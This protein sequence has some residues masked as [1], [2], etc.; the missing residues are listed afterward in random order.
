MLNIE[1]IFK[2]RVPNFSLLLESGFV[3]ED[4]K[5]TNTYPLLNNQFQMKVAIDNIGC[6]SVKVFDTSTDEEY[7]LIHTTTACGIFV[8]SVIRSCEEIL[9]TI[10]K[11]C[12][13]Y[14][15][16]KSQQAKQIIEYVNKT[17]QDS[18]EFLWDKFPNNAVLRRKD[19]SKW[20]A[21]ILTIA[22]NKLG[23]EG[24]ELVEIIVLRGLPHEI[25]KLLDN[26]K[27]FFGYHMNKK[28]WYTI[29][30]NNS[31]SINEIYQR[32]ESSYLIA[33]K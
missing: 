2:N 14:W 19:S 11:E 13:S 16:F 8:G 17:H 6:V 20:Y 10:A 15:V 3:Q 21:L 4:E 26:N 30:L 22:K 23:I 33:K 18:P 25:E 12:F 5:Y 28:H 31:V 27:Y 32:I 29:C 1:N 24:N 7:V 9:Q